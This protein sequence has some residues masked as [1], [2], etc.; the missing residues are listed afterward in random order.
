MASVCECVVDPEDRPGDHG[1]RS[2]WL[3][4]VNV[5]DPEDRPGDHGVRSQW[6]QYPGPDC[7]RGQHW[8]QQVYHPGVSHGSQTARWR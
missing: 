4:S 5:V 8:K 3:Q 6:L 7:V 2:Q 1:V